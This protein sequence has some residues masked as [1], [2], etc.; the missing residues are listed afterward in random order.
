MRK[1]LTITLGVLMVVIGAVW[2]FQGLGYLKGS[3]MTGV[4]LWAILGPLV[5]GLGVALAIVGVRSPRA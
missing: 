4:E 3:P 2:T 1:T 5:A